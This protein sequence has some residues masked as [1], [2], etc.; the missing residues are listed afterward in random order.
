MKDV[1]G[2]LLIA[3]A[4][5]VPPTGGADQSAPAPSLP[6]GHW[7][8]QGRSDELGEASRT[9]LRASDLER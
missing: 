9:R 2:T 7:L 1:I 4:A 5:A 8:P 3:A 6:A